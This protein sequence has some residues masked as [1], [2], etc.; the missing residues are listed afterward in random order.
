M[1]TDVVVVVVVVPSCFFVRKV[2]MLLL[3]LCSETAVLGRN[4][5]LYLPSGLI[6][7]FNT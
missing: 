2:V 3:L 5:D 1:E 6:D 7:Q 4:S